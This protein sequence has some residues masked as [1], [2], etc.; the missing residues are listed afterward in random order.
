M[1]QTVTANSNRYPPSKNAKQQAI[2]SNGVYILRII[3]CLPRL[4]S[5]APSLQPAKPPTINPK[6][7]NISQSPH[8]KDTKFDWPAYRAAQAAAKENNIQ[9]I[10][11]SND[12]SAQS[13]PKSP[14]K[15]EL[16]KVN[17]KLKKENTQLKC[18]EKENKKEMV[19]LKK[20]N[21]RLEAENKELL[22]KLN[23]MGANI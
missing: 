4:I 22:A 15:K 2:E 1:N 18:N 9:G 20:C 8:K 19:A 21:E 13:K 7:K 23:S 5:R 14:L 12:S 16:K 17:A 3:I 10:G 6:S 11:E